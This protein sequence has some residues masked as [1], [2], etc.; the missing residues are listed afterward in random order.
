[1]YFTFVV[2]FAPLPFIRAP[3][4]ER[5][6]DWGGGGEHKSKTKLVDLENYFMEKK[7]KKLPSH[8]CCSL[9]FLKMTRMVF[10][11]YTLY[12]TTFCNSSQAGLCKQIVTD[13][14]GSGAN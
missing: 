8:L 14:E 7:K 11:T 4:L 12:N 6:E 9:A 3:N 2:S 10:Y 13:P 5:W 1:M